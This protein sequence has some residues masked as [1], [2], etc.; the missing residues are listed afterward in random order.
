MGEEQVLC[1]LKQTVLADFLRVELLISL[2]A[3]FGLGLQ[4]S[5]ED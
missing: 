4:A 5:G 1:G 2:E 3:N